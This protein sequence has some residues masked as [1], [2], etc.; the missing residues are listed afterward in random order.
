[1]A[2]GPCLPALLSIARDPELGGRLRRPM[3]LRKTAIEALAAIAMA[4]G[5]MTKA[6]PDITADAVHSLLE[7]GIVTVMLG[8]LESSSSQTLSMQDTPSARIREGAGIVVSALSMCSAEAMVELQSCHAITTMLNAMGDAGSSTLR[9]DGAPKCLG[10]LQTAAALLTYSQHDETTPADLVDRLLEAVDAGAISTLARILFTKVEWESEDKAVGAMKA[11]D[12]ACRMLTA[13]FG[14]ARTDEIAHQRLWDVVDADAYERNPP[15]NIVTGAL[16]VLQAAGRVG[17]N[18]L[19]GDRTGTH[20][21][22]AVM[23]LVESS[24]YAV[25][26]MCGSTVVPGLEHAVESIEMM[27][28]N[29]SDDV[30]SARRREAC[31]V[32]CDILTARSRATQQAIL[33]TM[34][35]GGFGEKT[36]TASLRLALAICQNGNLEQHAKLAASGILIP[37]SDL[38]K[39][40][41]SSSDQFRFSACLALVR[42]CGPH[43]GTGTGGG[44]IASVQA[45]IRTATHILAVPTDPRAP[46]EHTNNTEALKAACIQTLESLSSN[47]S[48]W[49]AISK[50]ALPSV[51]TFL[52]AAS[53]YGS[54]SR[55]STVCGALRAVARIVGLQSH[56]VSAARAGLATPLGRLLMKGTDGIKLDDGDDELPLLA[57]EVL[58]VLSANKDA[59]REAGL[60]ESGVIEGVCCVLAMSATAAPKKPTDGRADICFWAIEILLYFVGDLGSDFQSALLSPLTSSFVEVVAREPRLIMALCSTLLLK[61]NMKIPK[62]NADEGEMLDVPSLYGP[63]LVLVKERCS[64]FKDTHC[65]AINLFFTIVVFSCALEDTGSESFW[66]AL[67]LNDQPTAD[68]GKLIAT[69]FAYFLNLLSEEKDSPFLPMKVGQKG[70]FDAIFRPLVRHALLE[71]LT[72]SVSECNGDEYLTSMLVA[73][74]VPRVCLSIW[75]DPN[76]MHLAFGLI[77]LMVDSHE[78]NLVHIFIESK[79]TLLS[80]FDMLNAS[81]D[82]DDVQEIRN[83]VASVLSN[84]AENGLLTRAVDKF[85]IRS[86]A[87]AGFAAAC[88]ADEHREDDDDKLA[89]SAT[90]S[91]RCMECLVDLLKANAGKSMQLD[92]SDA[93]SMAT[94]LGRKICRMVISRF[95]ERAKLSQYEVDEDEDVMDAP[96]VKMLCAI[97]QHESALNII[98]SAGGI[99]ALALV[100]GEGNL[101]AIVALKKANPTILFA[102]NGHQS[103]MKL[104]LEGSVSSDIETAALELLSE[105]SKNEKG[106]SAIADSDDCAHCIQHAL[107]VI[108]AY[109]VDEACDDTEFERNV[110]EVNDSND[111]GEAPTSN[112][113]GPALNPEESAPTKL[114][115]S[116]ST[117]LKCAALSFLSNLATV[118]QCRREMVQSKRFVPALSQMSKQDTVADLQGQTIRLIASLVPFATKSIG[119]L[120]VDT[121]AQALVNAMTSSSPTDTKGT[122][123]EGLMTIM[124]NVSPQLQ[125]TAM[126]TVVKNFTSSVKRTTIARSTEVESEQARL[127]KLVCSL[128]SLVVQMSTK[129]HLRSRLCCDMDLLKS[130]IHLIEW[131]YDAVGITPTEEHA[132]YWDA[133]VSFCIQHSATVLCGTLESQEKVNVMALTKT[134]LTMA[135]PGKAPRKTCDFRTALERVIAARRDASGAVAAQRILL[136]LSRFI[137]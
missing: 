134:V 16:G 10:M 114:E 89:T 92:R 48:L 108:G 136:H 125:C 45:A 21:H 116:S 82:T 61:T 6:N 101:A 13:I 81:A 126:E 24:L 132:M 37:V 18:S 133:A 96:D 80:L 22:A 30:F 75:K 26:S 23:D 90:L 77:K 97:A 28:L 66:K 15:R 91:S 117:E 71:G 1:M 79:Q 87:I 112:E 115:P 68:S 58:H 59:R 31:A 2:S 3:E 131:R 11:R 7:E 46:I 14:M 78:E 103:I 127:A 43:V 130:M 106:R 72:S 99:S 135:R 33:P 113:N 47:A 137:H 39:S 25:G 64:G 29:K 57:L 38:L 54:G 44:G 118:E 121:L 104:L 83:V 63:P 128:S 50:D 42:F 95:L 94:S 41:M 120:A 56:A 52:H 27:E 105:L 110:V 53:D 60:L 86:E 119:P 32:A 62:F 12:A 129:N 8:I 73:F 4:V 109:S 124:H 93:D 107:H 40:A 85:K 76:L 9:G 70:D 34:L 102:T 69:L 19:L 20:Y 51:V 111:E 100:A 49:S 67:S 88:L 5:E 98:S 55:I 84:L 123:S 35:V 36:L 65:A 17:R 122:A 74:E